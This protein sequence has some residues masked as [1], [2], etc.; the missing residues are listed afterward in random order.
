MADNA[1]RVFWFNDNKTPNV[2]DALSKIDTLVSNKL[3]FDSP[4]D[5]NW[6]IT[7]SYTHLT[8]PTIYSV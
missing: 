1:R 5:E 6:Q 4:E 3:E 7:V 8:L 2:Y